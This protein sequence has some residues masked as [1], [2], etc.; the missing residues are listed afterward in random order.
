VGASG[1]AEQVA[2]VGAEQRKE[3]GVEQGQALLQDG[4]LYRTRTVGGAE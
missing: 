1:G 3:S 2:Q 4:T